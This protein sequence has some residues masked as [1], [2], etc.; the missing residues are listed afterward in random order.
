MFPKISVCNR[1]TCCPIWKLLD[2]K[3]SEDSQL[4]FP[5]VENVQPSFCT[6]GGVL[7]LVFPSQV[8]KV[9]FLQRRKTFMLKRS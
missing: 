5:L 6:F 9:F 3:N 1:T 7:V 4:Y 8:R 2:E